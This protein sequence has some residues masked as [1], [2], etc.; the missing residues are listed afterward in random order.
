V[1]EAQLRTKRRKLWFDT[2]IS[3]ILASPW[4]A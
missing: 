2:D 1:R 3:S 4:A